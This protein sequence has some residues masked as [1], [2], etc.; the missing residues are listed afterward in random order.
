MSEFIV[1]NTAVLI[2]ILILPEYWPT[3]CNFMLLWGGGICLFAGSILIKDK[4]I[5]DKLI[6]DKLIK[7]RLGGVC[8][9]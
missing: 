2:I 4:L 5:K 8:L 6:K 3:D 7:Y 1:L 9:Q